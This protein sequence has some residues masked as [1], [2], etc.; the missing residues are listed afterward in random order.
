[1]ITKR[2]FAVPVEIIGPADGRMVYADERGE[3]ER[4]RFPSFS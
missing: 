2:Q 4:V 1:M 3:G